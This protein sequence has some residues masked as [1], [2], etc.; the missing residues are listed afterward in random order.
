MFQGT[1]LSSFLSRLSVTFVNARN[2]TLVKWQNTS[3]IL[4]AT[5]MSKVIS[6]RCYESRMAG[7]EEPN[8]S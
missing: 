4:I 1:W 5:D 7:V 2:N 3:N 8:W 6:R